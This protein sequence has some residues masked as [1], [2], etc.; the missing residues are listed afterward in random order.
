MACAL[1]GRSSLVHGAMLAREDSPML[2]PML[3]AKGTKILAKSLFKEL[4]SSGYNANQILG[5]STELIDLVT[6][7]LRAQGDAR[8]AGESPA[9]AVAP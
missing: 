8:P 4:R 2:A 3:D 1:L 7:D 9:E 6:R 5:L